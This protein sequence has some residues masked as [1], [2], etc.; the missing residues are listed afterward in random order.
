VALNVGTSS[1]LRVVWTGEAIGNIPAALWCYRVDSKRPVLGGALSEGG[2][3]WAWLRSALNLPSPESEEAAL[4]ALEPDGHG[5]TVLPFIAGERSPGWND[6]ARLTIE[7]ITAD[8]TAADVLRASLEAITYRLAAVYEQLPLG[9][10][11]TVIASGR[12]ILNSPAWLQIVADVLDRPVLA[13]DDTE[14]SARGT[15]LIAL[16]SAGLI[17]SIEEAT[18]TYRAR[19]VPDAEGHAR[20]RDAKERQDQLY[21]RVADS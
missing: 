12:A 9:D 10:D 6:R 7:G 18:F 3:V 15:A 8:T 1:A 2:N 4:Q 20:Y 21:K 11:R 17:G 5:L 13:L 16:Q 14:A 19:Y